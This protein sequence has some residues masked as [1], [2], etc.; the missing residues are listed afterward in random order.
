MSNDTSNGANDVA[1]RRLVEQRIRNRVIEYF[2]TASSFEAQ[3]KYA[4][5]VPVVNVLYGTR[6]LDGNR[7]FLGRGTRT[8]RG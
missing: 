2:D 1:S 4:R 7:K 5:D 8:V 3:M 6:V